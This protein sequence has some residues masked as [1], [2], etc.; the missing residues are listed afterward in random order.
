MW[1][2]FILFFDVMIGWNLY[3]QYD[4]QAR[5]QP[6]DAVVLGAYVDESRS[7]DSTTYKPR[8][9]YE[10]TVNGDEFV[11]DRYSFVL[12]GQGDR[13]YARSIVDRYPTGKEI[14]V[15]VD[16]GDP[17][18][19]VIDR[20]DDTFPSPVLLFLVPFH[21]VGIGGVLFYRRQYS[22]RMLSKQGRAMARYIVS[23][24]ADRV[25]LRD[26]AYS[27]SMVYLLWLGVSSFVSIFAVL[28]L[29]GGFQASRG[30]VL[31]AGMLCC[32]IASVAMGR[33]AKRRSHP[34]RRLVID[35]AAGTITRG[36][37]CADISSV[38]S[39]EIQSSTSSTI[40][41][42]SWYTHRVSARLD[43]ETEMDLLV[44]KGYSEH[45]RVLR[46]FLKRELGL[47]KEPGREPEPM[48]I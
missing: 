10:Y 26:Y 47:G 14:T 48:K 4:A 24:S 40:N 12:F 39:I 30:V 13:G 28:F 7:D 38:V 21:C 16:P 6:V 22:L 27:L 3:R 45:G 18:E 36:G 15:F 31:I 37:Q 35:S 11:G 23:Q 2:A 33:A 42:E 20:T 1:N 19:S 9:E 43:D 44:G 34:A 41:N 46:E 32:L 8:I 17:G 29:A 25:V 5:Y